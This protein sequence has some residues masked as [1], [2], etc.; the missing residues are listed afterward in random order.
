MSNT[1]STPSVVTTISQSRL[2]YNEAL[3]TLLQNFASA[4]Q[5]S[6]GDISTDGTTGLRTGMLWYKSGSD[7]TDGQGRMFIYDGSTFT[8]NGLITY[9][10]PSVSSANSA[11]VGSKISYGELVSVGTDALYMVN[12]ANTGVF[13]IGSDALTL[14]GLVSTQFVRTDATSTIT[15]NLTFSGSGFVKLPAGS[16][17]Q[18]PG[19]P[20]AG[21]FRF[22]SDTTSFEGYDGT[23]WGEVGGGGAFI[24]DGTSV[25]YTGSANVG[26]GTLTPAANLHVVGTGNLLRLQTGTSSDANGVTIRLQQTDTTI[27]VDQGYGGVEWAG[28]DTEGSG[29]RGYVRGVAEGASGEFGLRLATQGSGTSS[30]IDRVNISATGNVG[31][32]V[33]AN[34]RLQIA[35]NVSMSGGDATIFN[36]EN[37]YLALGANNNEAIRI[38]PNTNVGIGITA[39]TANLHVAGTGPVLKL[40]T[41]TG[42]DASGVTLRFV[43]SDTIIADVQ[44]YGGIEWEG[45]DFDGA[46]V[47]GHVKAFS[48]GTGGGLGVHIA[49]QGSGTS[50]PIDRLFIKSSGNVGIGVSNPTA[51]LQI[52]GLTVANVAHFANSNVSHASIGTAVV[53]IISGNSALVTN[54]IGGGLGISNLN[55]D[56]VTIGTINTARLATG[57]ANSAT[58]LRG[59]QTWAVVEAGGSGAYIENDTTTNNNNFYLAMATSNVAG[60]W[61]NAYISSNKLYFNPALG[62]LNAV[63]Y[64][65]TSDA[66]LKENIE[67]IPD[68]ISKLKVLQ[69]V[70]FNFIG[71]DTKLAGLMAQQVLSVLPEAVTESETGDL[72]VN[73]NAV[74]GLVVQAFN[75]YI[76]DTDNRL[77]ILEE[78]ILN[79]R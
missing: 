40:Q 72:S 29:V 8:R 73:Y 1:F 9:K 59:D 45:A 38:L 17:A 12:A 50:S 77:N 14:S 43:Q 37:F 70:F 60:Q 55:A 11:A 54:F 10:M 63:T 23:E 74:L 31:I 26:I 53:N 41:A 67:V 16:E 51:N 46:G 78:R 69:G 65:A 3:L 48:E 33:T 20:I 61:A 71:N 15:A 30:P 4:G 2:D 21:M 58:Y 34:T 19:T 27:T 18:R 57:T 5:P 76:I 44:G 7:T 6:G 22:N 52:Q 64:N 66:R 13:Q 28:L 75:T 62:R 24:D 42:T 36:R 49:T 25:H 32:G 39:P 79:D 47:R 56:N 35:G 68:S